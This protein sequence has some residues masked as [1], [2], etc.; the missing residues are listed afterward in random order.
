MQTPSNP[1][2]PQWTILTIL[3]WT[4]A[5]FKTHPV[6]SPRL[7]AEILLAHVLSAKRID[8]YARFDQPLTKS[9]LSDFKALIKRR[10]RREP[11]AYI[12]GS[13]EFFGIDFDV[14]PFV[15]IPRPETEFLVEAALARI[16]QAGSSFLRILEIGAGSGAVIVS[17]AVNR[18]GHD[19]M[20]SDI[21]INALKT[22][23][24]NAKK[25]GV[26][27]KIFFFAGDLFTPLNP[28][29]APFDLI[30]SNPPYIAKPDL[31][32]LEPEVRDFEPSLALDG[33]TDGLDIIRK[34]INTA[35]PFLNPNAPLMLEIGYDQ[36]DRV[37]RIAALDGRYGPPEFIKDY[38]GHH[39]VAIMYKNDA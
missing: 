12:S 21:S 13:R 9:E 24:G 39:R 22:A 15:L 33:G 31:A 1:I 2:D 7:T 18:P 36:K 5:Y 23:A 38:A 10:V 8:L 29:A 28:S 17:L 16:P 14:T 20:A 26:P 6:D 35:P 3:Q 4:T 19:Y 37:A 27:G 34:I 11:V 25:N 32:G 30:V